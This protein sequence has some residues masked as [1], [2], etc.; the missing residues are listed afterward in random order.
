MK[1]LKRTVAGAGSEGQRVKT[2]RKIRKK[3]GFVLGAYGA[4]RSPPGL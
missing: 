2:K 1:E 4:G 3:G